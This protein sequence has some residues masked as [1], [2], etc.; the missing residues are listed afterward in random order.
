[1]RVLVA[2]TLMLA[3][4]LGH[5]SAVICPDGITYTDSAANKCPVNITGVT[6]LDITQTTAN[7]TATADAQAVSATAYQY[8]TSSPY[9]PGCSSLNYLYAALSDPVTATRQAAEKARQK[10]MNWKTIVAGTG[11]ASFGSAAISVPGLYSIPV[12]TDTP[13]TSSATFYTQHLVMG[14]SG[15]AGKVS[16]LSTAAFT[17]N[18]S[19]ASPGESLVDDRNGNLALAAPRFIGEGG[20]DGNTGLSHAQR[21]LNP[22]KVQSCG[23][24]AGTNIALLNTSTFTGS[25]SVMALCYNSTAADW[26]IVSSYK[27]SGTTGEP[28]WTVDGIR[29]ATETDEKAQFLGPITQGCIDALTCDYRS[30]AFVADG[31]SSSYTPRI[32]IDAN[33]I[34]VRNIEFEKQ[35]GYDWIV[36]GSGNTFYGDTSAGST[37]H[38]IIDGIDS[39]QAGPAANV[40]VDGVRDVVYRNSTVDT[41]GLCYQLR[42]LGNSPTLTDDVCPPVAVPSAGGLVRSYNAR[43]LIENN[44][45]YKGWGEGGVDCGNHTSHVIYT[46]NRHYGSTSVGQYMDGCA[47]VVVEKAILVGGNDHGL[48]GAGNTGPGEN[49]SASISVGIEDWHALT[50]ISPSAVIRNNLQVRPAK[51]YD[52]FISIPHTTAGKTISVKAFGNSCIGPTVQDVQF[53]QGTVL[54]MVFK[55]NLFWNETVNYCNLPS[56]TV[57]SNNHSY[58]AR[59]DTDCVGTSASTGNPQLV[60][61]YSSWPT[62]KG[63]SAWPA[64]TDARPSPG[65]PLIDTGVSSEAVVLTWADYGFAATEMADFKSG[66]ISSTHWVKERYYDALNAVVGATPPKGAVCAAAGC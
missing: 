39:Y 56:S 3:C 61:A 40:F 44:D 7:L 13:L 63:P 53:W 15:G 48:V 8:T 49:L 12:G 47:D 45:F 36:A 35:L 46:G 22:S 2:L 55:S 4:T 38:V 62:Y 28:I 41:W 18:S 23:F 9:P 27:I 11:A 17:T 1:M 20:S 32:Y 66:A 33:Y 21:W 51:C 58:A 34:E 25:G 5:A 42:S 16:L 29:G 19:G 54:A 24:A 37:H 65:S 26:A 57:S 60:T 30:S 64:F 10:C 43:G 6:L 31:L 50:E 59:T 52:L 14:G